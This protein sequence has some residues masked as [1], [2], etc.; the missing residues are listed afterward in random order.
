MPATKKYLLAEI[1][2][3]FETRVAHFP[4]TTKEYKEAGTVD[5]TFEAIN[6]HL[7]RSL[8]RMHRSRR[9]LKDNRQCF[10]ALFGMPHF[11]FRGE[12]LYHGYRFTFDGKN[13]YVLTAKTKGT[14]YETGPGEWTAEQLHEFHEWLDTVCLKPYEEAAAAAGRARE[15][16][17]KRARPAGRVTGTPITSI[18][19]HTTSEGKHRND[20]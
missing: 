16:E 15:L 11:R 12:F 14:G 6:A 7:D 20:S 9:L 18:S 10:F 13:V 8:A 2:R 3:N 4:C 5:S 17:R 1:R 19:T